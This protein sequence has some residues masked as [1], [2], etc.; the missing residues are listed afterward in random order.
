MLRAAA[1]QIDLKELRRM[2]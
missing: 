2:H 1:H